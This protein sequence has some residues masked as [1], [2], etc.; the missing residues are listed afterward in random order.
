MIDRQWTS[1]SPTKP[2]TDQNHHWTQASK[3]TVIT[4]NN[5]H[6]QQTSRKIS[7]SNE[8][9][10]KNDLHKKQSSQ[11]TTI[12]D[13]NHHWKRPSLTQHSRKQPSRTATFIDHR[14]SSITKA[15]SVID[16]KATDQSHHWPKPLPT[17]QPSLITDYP[18][19]PDDLPM[20]TIARKRPSHSFNSI[21]LTKS[22]HEEHNLINAHD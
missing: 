21:W 6:R 20:L 8:T 13:E 19:I 5:H 2:F 14:P 15:S 12:T 3:T 1:T 18:A 22:V 9:I 4:E 11:T 16:Y 7:I 10:I 17:I